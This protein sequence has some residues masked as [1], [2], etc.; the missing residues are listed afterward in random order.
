[1]W[2]TASMGL[3]SGSENAGATAVRHVLPGGVPRVPENHAVRTLL[4]LRHAHT[5]DTRP[6][7]TDHAR[8]LTDDGRAEASGLGEHLRAQGVRVDRVL[9]SSATRARQTL[10]AL[11]LDCPVDVSD[12]VYNAGSDQILDLVGDTPDDVSTLLVVGHAPGLPT[13]AL[14]LADPRQSE[15]DALAVLETRFP[16]CSMATLEVD[17]PWAGLHRA[18]LVSVRLA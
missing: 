13:L 4:V 17:G 7:H 6:G 2:Q 1:M 18:R 10:G 15:P 5:E 12:G 3:P 8:R 11:G 14:D 16:P 9:C